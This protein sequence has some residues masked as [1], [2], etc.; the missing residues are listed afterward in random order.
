LIKVASIFDA[1]NAS[2]VGANSVREAAALS[3]FDER[4]DFC[5]DKSMRLRSDLLAISAFKVDNFTSGISSSFL[6]ETIRT[7][8]RKMLIKE[9]K[10]DTVCF[11]LYRLWA[12]L[13]PTTNHTN[14]L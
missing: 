8:K 1:A 9:E 2:F 11:I 4:P 14:D 7:E 10:K 12:N 13:N 6:Q 5:T 3:N